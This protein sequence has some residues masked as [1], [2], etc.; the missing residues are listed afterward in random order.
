MS[1]HI[2]FIGLGA[3]GWPMA[4]CLREAGFSLSVFDAQMGVAD[5]FAGLFGAQ[6]PSSLIDLARV[7]D[8]II[9]MLP[10]SAIVETVL[11]GEGGVVE[12]LK[13]GTIVIEMS[14]G[15]PAKTQAMARALSLAGVRLIDAPVSGGTRRAETGELAII[16]GGVGADIEGVTPVLMAM[17]RSVQ[18]VGE[19]GAGQAMKALNNLAQAGSFLIAL[20]ALLI[21]KKFGLVPE[22]IVDVLNASSGMNYNTQTKFKQFLLTGTYAAGFALEHLAKDCGIALDLAGELEAQAPFA[23]RCAQLWSE[24]SQALGPGHDHTEI[25]RISALAMN[26][27]FP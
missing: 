8:V 27:E 4:R 5:K 6:A 1:L 18:R 20:E 11:L 3:M 22:T 12:A 23:E 25:A 17:G 7:A 21:G 24:A 26:V 16:A 19:V 9:T 14:S 15:V 2:G 13:P 10:T